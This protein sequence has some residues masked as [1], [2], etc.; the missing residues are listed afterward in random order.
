MFT[1]CLRR[2]SQ[3]VALSQFTLLILLPGTFTQVW[4]SCCWKCVTLKTLGNVFV[5]CKNRRRHSWLCCVRWWQWGIGCRWG[6]CASVSI[7]RMPQIV[8]LLIKEAGTLAVDGRKS[9]MRLCF[10]AWWKYM[11]RDLGYIC[12]VAGSG[13]IWGCYKWARG[14][15]V[16]M[17]LNWLSDDVLPLSLNLALVVAVVT[18]P[19]S[20]L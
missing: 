19:M 6:V 15:V 14:V 9:A 17:K 8:V 3:P 13:C 4:F 18:V 10:S 2:P 20:D 7:T 11:Y 16:V 5:P 12:D 1:L